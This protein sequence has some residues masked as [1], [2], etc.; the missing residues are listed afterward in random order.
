MSVLCCMSCLKNFNGQSERAVSSDGARIASFHSSGVISLAIAWICA[1]RDFCLSSKG[2]LKKSLRVWSLSHS[3]SDR[4]A[5]F[6]IDGRVSGN[7]FSG[8]GG[9]AGIGQCCSS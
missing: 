5:H 1:R 6:P 3:G 9:T 7:V 2:I 8:I 4:S